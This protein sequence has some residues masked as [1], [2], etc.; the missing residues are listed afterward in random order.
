MAAVTAVAAAVGGG[1]W[2]GLVVGAGA[3]PH[4]QRQ[5]DRQGREEAA[6]GG[7]DEAE[8]GPVGVL[9]HDGRASD[10]GGPCHGV[11]E[12]ASHSPFDVRSCETSVAAHAVHPCVVVAIAGCRWGDAGGRGVTLHVDGRILGGVVGGGI[13]PWGG[14]RGVTSGSGEGEQEAKESS[15][16]KMRI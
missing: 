3:G 9:H 14:A 12:S 10:G 1:G 13:G 5:G 16:N 4:S 6:L 8:L 7:G 11:I 2:H 15:G